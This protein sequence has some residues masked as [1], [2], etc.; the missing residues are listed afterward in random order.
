MLKIIKLLNYY[1]VKKLLLKLSWYTFKLECYNFRML[2]V[3]PKLNR[4]QL[5]IYRKGRK[6]LFHYKKNQVNT[7][8]DSNAE[9]K[10]KKKPMRHRETKQQNDK[11]SLFTGNHFKYRWVKPQSRELGRR[12]LKSDL[13]IYY[14]QKIHFKSKDTN[15]LKV[16]RLKK[17]FHANSNLRRTGM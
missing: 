11:S 15:R 17:I 3:F 2:N 6:E 14:P 16:K 5:C 10:T 4:K 12:D 7:K 8:E 13:T 1:C 9:N